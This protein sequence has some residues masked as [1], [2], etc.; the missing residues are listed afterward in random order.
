[1]EKRGVGVSYWLLPAMVCVNVMSC[2]I[3]NAVCLCNLQSS[4]EEI[5]EMSSCSIQSCSSTPPPVWLVTEPCLPVSHDWSVADLLLK[6]IV[7]INCPLPPSLME[8]SLKIKCL[9]VRLAV[10]TCTPSHFSLGWKYSLKSA[11][12]DFSLQLFCE[13]MVLIYY[14]KEWS[15]F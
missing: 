6:V 8:C 15:Q 1:M 3:S 4:A 13:A 11:K 10:P 14:M 2:W 9:V 5:N 12:I 7:L